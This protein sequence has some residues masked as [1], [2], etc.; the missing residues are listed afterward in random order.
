VVIAS[1]IGAR[2]LGLEAL[3]AINR[4]EVGRGFEDGISAEKRL[5]ILTRAGKKVSIYR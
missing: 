3:L 2:G 1:M 4:I 5:T